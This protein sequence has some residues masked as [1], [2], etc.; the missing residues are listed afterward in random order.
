MTWASWGCSHLR[1]T[2][3]SLSAFY[4]EPCINHGSPSHLTHGG[5]ECRKGI[6]FVLQSTNLSVKG[7]LKSP[8]KL[9]WE[10]ASSE[11]WCTRVTWSIMLWA[12]YKMKQTLKNVIN[13]AIFEVFTDVLPKN[14]VGCHVDWRRWLTSISNLRR[15]AWKMINFLRNNYN[16]KEG[17]PVKL[18][19][20]K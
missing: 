4:S 12:P 1:C 16:F 3:D 8:L 11:N 17:T 14:Q 7:S 18:K 13:N 6:L 10:V 20:L 5:L 2:L 19:K 15:F 9:Q